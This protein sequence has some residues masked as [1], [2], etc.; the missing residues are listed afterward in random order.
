MSG[1]VDVVIC[2]WSFWVLVFFD[3]EKDKIM[4]KVFVVFVFVVLLFV[5]VYVWWNV[6]W[7]E[8]ICI[9][10]N[11]L[12]QGLEI[13]EVVSGV[14]VVV[15]LYSGNFDF[16]VVK[17]DG[18]DLCV[19]VVDDKMLLKFSVEC[20]DGVNELV[21][22]WVQLFSVLLGSD[23]NVFYVYVGNVKVLVEVL[24]VGS[25]DVVIVI[26]LYFS[27]CFVGGDQ[28][29]VVKFQGM[30]VIEFNGLLV[31]S[32]WLSGELVV[33]VLF[34]KLVV[35]VGNQL[36]VS[37]WVK[38]DD[39]W[40]VMLLNWGGLM[41]GLS[42]GKFVVCVDKVEVLGGEVVLVCWMQ[43]VFCLGLGK[44]IFF[45]NGVQVE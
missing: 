6:D 43:V 42:G 12:V 40:C 2:C 10:F 35:D 36:I 17:E 7:S 28:F 25:F 41:L 44:V 9:I 32:V 38:L 24:E 37:L 27:D 30:L 11:I 22:L 39:V 21:V 23:K 34:D 26:V 45:V 13:Q 33:Y 4:C 18:S 14:F 20:F 5:I 15:C 1:V 29:G 31:V 8:C 19:V 3:F 16:I